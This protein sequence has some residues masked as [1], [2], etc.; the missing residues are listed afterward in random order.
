MQ[1][2]ETK[3]DSEVRHAREI[4]ASDFQVN[5]KFLGQIQKLWS[6]H[7][8]PHNVRAE[9]YETHLYGPGGHFKSHRDTP[10]M[11]LVGTSWLASVTPRA[12]LLG[13]SI[14]ATGC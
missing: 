14:L 2:L 11:N 12:L 3:V 8:L 6:K 4:H 10:E 5:P 13:T 1:S 7:F 9:P